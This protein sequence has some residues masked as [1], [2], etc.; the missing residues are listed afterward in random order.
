MTSY[1][2]FSSTTCG[3]CYADL[4]AR[5]DHP[6]PTAA[7]FNCVAAWYGQGNQQSCDR[8]ETAQAQGSSNIVQ[9]VALQHLGPEPICTQPIRR[10][11]SMHT[12]HAAVHCALSIL[13]HGCTMPR[14]MHGSACAC[15]LQ[16]T[17]ACPADICCMQQL[18]RGSN[19]VADQALSA[20]PG[21][22]QQQPA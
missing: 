12:Q 22:P 14:D 10:A 18:L 3:Q 9:N 21:L 13:S 16:W 11:R 4:A 8:T 6:V 19:A 5:H 20:W 7:S 17:P 15:M 1:A 2:I